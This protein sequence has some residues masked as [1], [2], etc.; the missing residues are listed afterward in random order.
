MTR[1]GFVD[2]P[3]IIPHLPTYRSKVHTPYCVIF[4]LPRKGTMGRV[5]LGSHH[6]PRGSFIEAVNDPGPRDTTDSGK[7]PAVIQQGIDKSARRVTMGWMN[8]HMGSLVDDNEITVFIEDF[9]GQFLLYDPGGADLG[10]VD[11]N[12]ITCSQH[13][14]GLGR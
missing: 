2:A 6:D 7:V 3:L 4:K 13:G 8:Y 14:S 1:K 12:N 11:V 10:D 9:Q 5:I